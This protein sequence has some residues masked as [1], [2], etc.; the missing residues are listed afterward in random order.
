MNKTL[1][2]AFMHR[3]KLKNRYNKF[4]TEI[5]LNNYKKH[6]NYCVNLLGREKKKFY[7]NLDLWILNDKRKFWK[8]IKPLFSNKQKVLKKISP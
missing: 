4:P 1:S 6:R 5:N 8:N 2:K 3:S 7:N